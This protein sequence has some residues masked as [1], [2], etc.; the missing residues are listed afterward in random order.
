MLVQSFIINVKINEY[1]GA[2]Y[3]DKHTCIWLHTGTSDDDK[4]RAR[5]QTLYAY[6][7]FV[8]DQKCIITFSGYD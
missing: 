1:E 2:Q 5:S 4:D 3:E 6:I 7:F 8:G